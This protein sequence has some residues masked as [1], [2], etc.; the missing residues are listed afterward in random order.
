MQPSPGRPTPGIGLFAIFVFVL[1]AVPKMNVKIGPVP[2]YF[3][4]GL[5]VLL[6]F[7]AQKLPPLPHGRRP[8]AGTIQVILI[9]ALVSEMIGMARFGTYLESGYIIIRTCLAFSVFFIASQMVRNVADVA[10]VLRAVVLGTIVTASLMILTSLPQTREPVMDLVF[11]H[12]ILEPATNEVVDDYANAGESGVRGRTLVGV[13]ILGATFI[14][15]CWPIVAM[16]W[17]WP[18]RLT[19]MWRN[20]A[21]LGCLLAPMGVLMSYSRG[22]ILG[23]ILIVA[24]ALVLGLRRVRRGILVPV[25]LG[26]ALV[27]VVGVG[28]QLFFFDRLVNRTEAMFDAPM[29]DERES[30]RFLA[31]SQPFEHVI[32]HPAFALFGEGITVR[33]AYVP[34][35]VQMRGQATHALFAI[36][37]YAYGMVA[38]VLYIALLVRLLLRL[39]GPALSRDRKVHSMMAQVLFVSALALVPWIAFGH[40]AVSTPRGAMLF[41]LVIGLASGLEHFR[42]PVRRPTRNLPVYHVSSRHPAIG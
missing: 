16:A 25:V 6:L 24:A 42:A 36:S 15:V 13:S 34:G 38:A 22:P 10:V 23:S 18:W 4:D 26:V 21:M 35:E 7:H 1:I 29:Q 17:L 5:I 11:S 12:S 9:L 28:S 30:E 2:F 37:Y 33:F 41:F 40:A 20:L 3:I 31:Y 19:G 39:A 8:F 14:N 27:A 32:E